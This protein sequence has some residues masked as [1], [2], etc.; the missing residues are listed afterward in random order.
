MTTE[1]KK[2]D[3]MTSWDLLKKLQ[4][5][6][7]KKDKECWMW[8]GAT[9][10]E[11][12]VYAMDY[13]PCLSRSMYPMVV[14]WAHGPT[15]RSKT[16]MNDLIGAY[17]FAP[18]ISTLT[19]KFTS[20]YLTCSKCNPGGMEKVPTNHLARPLYP[21][22]RIQIDHIRMP[23]S[24]GF[25]CGRGRILRMAEVFPS[26]EPVSKDYCK[27][28]TLRDE[29]RRYG[30]PEVICSDQGPAFTANLT[31]EIWSTVGSDLGLSTP[32]N[33]QSSEKSG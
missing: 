15:H 29:I 12:R 9:H 7:Q 24:G 10:E 27:E 26:E 32:Y 2:P 20:S 31:R 14:Q 3:Q 22:Q 17:W 8:N 25:E 11:G 19:A 5:Q 4:E 33:P 18:G 16:Q 13:E 21:F 6:T 23:P 28:T 1:D 30:V